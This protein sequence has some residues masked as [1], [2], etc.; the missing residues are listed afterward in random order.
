[1]SYHLATGEYLTDWR[2]ILTEG[3]DLDLFSDTAFSNPLPATSLAADFANAMLAL[4][5]LLVPYTMLASG[6]V[7]HLA[8]AAW[9]LV[10]VAVFVVLLARAWRRDG[11]SAR[12]VFASA[13]VIAFTLTQSTFEPDYGTFLRHQTTLL[14][15]LAF[16][17]ME[18]LWPAPA[19]RISAGRPD[20]PP[21]A[22]VR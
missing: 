8:F 1:V 12:L 9:E 6:K 19:T 2:N 16:I 3:R 20:T 10:N 17:A 5:R 4:L 21:P 7:Q 13:W 14:P 11:A 15:M 18:T 22:P